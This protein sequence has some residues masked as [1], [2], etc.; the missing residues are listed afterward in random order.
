MIQPPRIVVLEDIYIDQLVCM[1]EDRIL[2]LKMLS[3]DCNVG[4]VVWKLT[5]FV[6][7]RKRLCV[8]GV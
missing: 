1:T 2:T 7:R 5:L 4:N 6:I 3:A 8:K